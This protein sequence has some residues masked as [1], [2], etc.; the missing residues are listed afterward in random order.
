MT[1]STR[2]SEQPMFE[3]SLR[4]LARHAIHFTLM[5][6]VIGTVSSW[7][8]GAEPWGPDLVG[9]VVVAMMVPT[10]IACFGPERVRRWANDLFR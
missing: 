3:P 7:V 10:A 5:F 2:S 8:T 6:I 4:C 9:A 1:D